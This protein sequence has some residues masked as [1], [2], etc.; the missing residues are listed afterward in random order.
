MLL[1]WLILLGLLIVGILGE[2]LFTRWSRRRDGGEIP[3]AT[4]AAQAD[5][6]AGFSVLMWLMVTIGVAITIALI[7]TDHPYLLESSLPLP[8]PS[9]LIEPV[10]GER[11]AAEQA[12]LQFVTCYITELVLSVD[13]LL[14]WSL[15]FRYYRVARADQARLLFFGLCIGLACRFGMIYLSAAAYRVYEHFGV[16]LG[17]VVIAAI[18]RTMLLPDGDTNFDRRPGIRLIRRLF[19]LK[20]AGVSDHGVDAAQKGRLTLL[21]AVLCGLSDFTYAFDSVPVAFSITHDPFIIF[22]S[23]ACVVVMLRSLYLAMQP[24][25]HSFRYVKLALVVL[26]GYFA[27]KLFAAPALN[28]PPWLTVAVVGGVFAVASFASWRYMVSRGFAPPV[29]ER[30]APLADLVDA[31]MATRRNLR[32]ITILIAGT[33]LM[34]SAAVVGPLP[35]PGG[36]IVFFA[37]LG[38]LATEFVWARKLL[39]RLKREAEKIGKT[40]DVVTA[41]TGLWPVPVIIAGYAGL[42]YVVVRFGVLPYSIAVAVVGGFAFPVALVLMRMVTGWWQSRRSKGAVAK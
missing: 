16:V 11:P 21:L 14:L 9:D 20:A 3:F 36:S 1:L 29:Q 42:G 2:S 24:V 25:L 30:P 34:C 32:K 27:V 37:G 18:V 26:L 28:S 17:C 19:G 31:A 13:N 23:S 41:R 22:A 15:L 12:L 38:L 33:L 4:P 10:R 35:G 6:Q 8:I 5:G 7:Y 40:T 39:K